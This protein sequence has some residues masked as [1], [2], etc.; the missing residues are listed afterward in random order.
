M[1]FGI[2]WATPCLEITSL[3][4]ITIIRKPHLWADK[5]DN[6]VMGNDPA[7]VVNRAMSHRPVIR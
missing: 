5:I 2:S 6:L 4:I 7:V 1:V 3:A